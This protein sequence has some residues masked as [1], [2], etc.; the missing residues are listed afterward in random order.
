MRSVRLIAAILALV[1]LSG[2]RTPLEGQA[3]AADSVTQ[4]LRQIERVAL[5]GNADGYLDLLAATAERNAALN[6]ARAELPAG[7]TR[8]AVKERDRAPLLGTLP[9]NG[10]RLTVDVFIE[11]GARARN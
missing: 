9:G 5:S 3:P 1:A 11:I 6:F 10:Y 8:V 4:L 2:G 7:A